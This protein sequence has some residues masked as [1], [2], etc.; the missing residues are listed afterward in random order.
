MILHS[1]FWD[2]SNSSNGNY[3]V[4][5]K[6]ALKLTGS[7]RQATYSVFLFTF[8]MNQEC[9]NDRGIKFVLGFTLIFPWTD[10]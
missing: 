9:E 1:L 7:L 6:P 8:L 10:N 5:T 3:L 4:A 2:I